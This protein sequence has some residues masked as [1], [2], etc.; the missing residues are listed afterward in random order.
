[1][2][3]QRGSWRELA[4]AYRDRAARTH[5]SARKAEVLTSLA[6]VFEHRLSDPLSAARAYGEVAEL[7]GDKRALQEQVRLL[8][9]VQ[10]TTGVRKVLDEAVERAPDESARVIALVARGDSNLHR[11]E[12]EAARADFLAAVERE[13]TNLV[14]QLGLAETQWKLGP[15]PSLNELQERL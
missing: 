11:R 14:A 12:L 13:P 7:T 4:Q 5:N 2:Y 3:A 8:S 1:R 6:E 15:A 10:S 9:K